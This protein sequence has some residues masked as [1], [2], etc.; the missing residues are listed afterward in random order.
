MSPVGLIVV[1]AG[2]AVCG[3]A[4]WRQTTR[5]LYYRSMHSTIRPP[6]VAEQDYESWVITRR[7][8]WRLAK[9]T[10]FAGLG[11][12]AAWVLVVMIDSGLAQQ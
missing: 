6:H 4:M 12:A 3:Y 10:L 9:S 7:K 5:H 11:A 2:G 1:V 8:R